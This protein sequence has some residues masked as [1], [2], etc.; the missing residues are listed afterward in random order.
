MKH[1]AR[2]PYRVRNQNS[3]PLGSSASKAAS[4]AGAYGGSEAGAALGSLVGPPVIGGIVGN[5]VGERVGQDL[6]RETGLDRYDA[7]LGDA[8]FQ[9]KIVYQM[10]EYPVYVN[11]QPTELTGRRVN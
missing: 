6:I 10:V 5:I 4:K 9:Q 8:H 1:T 7:F 3:R 2:R 11:Q